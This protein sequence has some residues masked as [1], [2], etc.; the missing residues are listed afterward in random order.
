LLAFEG[1]F[2]LAG[3]FVCLAGVFETFAGVFETFTGDFET[4]AGVFETFDGLF[5][6]FAGDFDSFTG[7]LACL[8]GDFDF[9]AG[10]FVCFAGEGE[11]L[12]LVG[13]S[14]LDLDFLGDLSRFLDLPCLSSSFMS[15]SGCGWIWADEPSTTREGSS[16]FFS[17]FAGLNAR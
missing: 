4:F 5:E 12:A 15:T 16:T 9:L 2:A 17:G 10:D 1:D 11:T 8:A 7:D 6:T 14:N 3:D 13:D